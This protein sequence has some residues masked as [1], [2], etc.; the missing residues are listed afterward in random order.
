MQHSTQKAKRKETN[1][2]HIFS[3]FR[4]LRPV[5]KLQVLVGKNPVLTMQ[6][7]LPIDSGVKEICEQV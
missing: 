3:L 2:S 5:L 7:T 4:I 6:W 1:H